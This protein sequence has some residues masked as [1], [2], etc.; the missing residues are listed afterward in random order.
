MSKASAA[1]GRLRRKLWNNNDVTIRVK[2]QVYRAIVLTTLLYGSETW[3]LYKS[4]VR[5][6]NS[7]MMK[8]LRS[9]MKV[10]R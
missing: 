7:F 8:Q 6:L 2:C 1:F 10:K 9:I 5:K 4:Q 3:T